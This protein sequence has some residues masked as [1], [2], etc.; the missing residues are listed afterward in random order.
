MQ[1]GEMR[2]RLANSGLEPV[3]HGADGMKEYIANQRRGF[4]TAIRAA[5]IRIDG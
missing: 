1:S 5:N 3:Y 4:A 2:E